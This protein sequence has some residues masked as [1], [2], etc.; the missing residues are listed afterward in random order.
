MDAFHELCISIK[1]WLDAQLPGGALGVLFFI[2]LCFDGIL[3]RLGFV[4]W[5]TERV[6]SKLAGEIVSS[7]PTVLLTTF[8]GWA[9]TGIFVLDTAAVGFLEGVFGPAILAAIA[10]RPK[11]PNS[12]AVGLALVLLFLPGCAAFGNFAKTVDDV[13]KDACA[14]Y[15]GEKAGISIR[16]AAKIYCSTREALDP[17]IEEIKAGQRRA[18]ARASAALEE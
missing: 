16:D 2:G 17:W 18:G 14:L 15:F 6:G 11:P 8:W 9:T 13:A 5:C 4:Q 12:T 10:N 3:R 1:L 7:G